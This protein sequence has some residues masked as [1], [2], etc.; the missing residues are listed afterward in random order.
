MSFYNSALRPSDPSDG[1]KRPFKDPLKGPLK[2]PLFT[3]RCLITSDGYG[4]DFG[5]DF[6]ADFCA[7]FG[8]ELGADAETRQQI[9]APRFCFEFEAV[10][11][12]PLLKMHSEY[13]RVSSEKEP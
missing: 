10:D 13:S 7:D 9:S 12:S 6:G 4:T 8:A 1:R 2:G 3:P 11:F 5:A